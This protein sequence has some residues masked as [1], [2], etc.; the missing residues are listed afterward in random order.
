MA[1]IG[2]RGAKIGKNKRDKQVKLLDYL[3]EMLNTYYKNNNVWPGRIILNKETKEKIFIELEKMDLTNCWKDK[4][5][6]YRG[7]SLY[8]KKDVFIESE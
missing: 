6:N 4:Q 1:R 3:D 2:Q 7:I 8:I 5:D